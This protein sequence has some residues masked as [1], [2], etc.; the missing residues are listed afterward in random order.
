MRSASA[1]PAIALAS[2]T[3]AAATDRF[4]LLAVAWAIKP[5]RRV[6][7]NARHHSPRGWLSAGCASFQVV[8]SWALR[9]AS[10][11]ALGAAVCDSLKAAGVDTAGWW[12]AGAAQALSSRAASTEAKRGANFATVFT[13]GCATERPRGRA[14]ASSR[15]RSQA[16]SACG[17]G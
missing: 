2:L 12:K 16:C 5:S 3:R 15:A 13:T 8:P 4:W 11:D 10:G 17:V 7:L 1:M 14:S 9:T 6:S